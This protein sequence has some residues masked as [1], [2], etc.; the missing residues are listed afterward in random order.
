MNI[1]QNV[2]HHISIDFL[3]SALVILKY[4]FPKKIKQ[5]IKFHYTKNSVFFKRN[6]NYPFFSI[7]A[8]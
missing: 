8:F 2:L 5:L 6:V 1:Q 4:Y 3:F 7:F